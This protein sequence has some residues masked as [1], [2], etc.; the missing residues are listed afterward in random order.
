MSNNR[1]YFLLIKKMSAN[2]LSSRQSSSSTHEKAEKKGL[3]RAAPTHHRL[4]H[5]SQDKEKQK[6]NTDTDSKTWN[7]SRPQKRGLKI[8]KNKRMLF[9][10][11]T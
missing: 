5:V 3:A 8:P 1:E 11:Q 9:N 4:V 7:C 2:I 10:D 6:G